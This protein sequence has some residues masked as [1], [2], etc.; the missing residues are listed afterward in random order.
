MQTVSAVPLE[1]T[2]VAGIAMVPQTILN[3]TLNLLIPQDFTVMGEAALGA[4]YPEEGGHPLNA[5]CLD[6]NGAQAF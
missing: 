3:E 4:K 1:E 2:N 5:S 6:G